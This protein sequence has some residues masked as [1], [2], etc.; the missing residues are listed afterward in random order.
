MHF[1]GGTCVLRVPVWLL[2]DK[3]GVGFLLLLWVLKMER[4]SRG[5]HKG[6]AFPAEPLLELIALFCMYLTFINSVTF[7]ATTHKL[8]KANDRCLLP[9]TEECRH[10]HAC[11]PVY[12][13]THICTPLKG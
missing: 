12:T 4:G 6:T 10:T 2:R 11:T 1:E 5:L 8:S 9:G 13:H 7:I 3:R